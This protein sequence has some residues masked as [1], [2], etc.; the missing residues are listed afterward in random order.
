MP[1]NNI[2][3]SAAVITL[4]EEKNIR[5]CLTSL[6]WVDEIIVVDSLSPDKTKEIAES[7]GAKVIDQAF[8]GHVKQKQLAVDSCTHD[9]VIALDADERVTDSLRDEIASLFRNTNESDLLH[10]YSVARKSFHLGRWIMHG[11]WY[12]D[13]NIRLF[14][15]KA[16][17]WTGT[18][19]HDVITVE[20]KAGHLKSALEHY[21]FN[22]LKHNVQTN[23]SYSSISARILFEEN[24]K[25]SLLKLL[26][27]PFGKF[28]ETYVVKRGFL[29]GMPG[30]II[31]VGAAYSMFLKY[32]KLWEH[33][34]LNNKQE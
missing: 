33:Y 31:A 34:R 2:Y 29:D 22:D 6:S 14:N 21:V 23:N 3:I 28:I 8:L 1:I 16:G 26:F 25:P 9:W 30:F 13:R 11:G 17:Y 12:P 32:A 15:R 5:D 4:N 18:N 19:P 20:G 24:K 10:G 27:K 7:M